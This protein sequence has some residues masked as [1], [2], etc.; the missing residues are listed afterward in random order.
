MH[1]FD[2]KTIFLFFWKQNLEARAKQ[3]GHNMHITPD[4]L[5]EL[6]M[7]YRWSRGGATIR[8]IALDG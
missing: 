6:I 8:N 3:L 5:I 7:Y 4:M 1:T 2:W